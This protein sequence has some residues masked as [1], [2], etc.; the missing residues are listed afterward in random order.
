VCEERIGVELP[1]CVDIQADCIVNVVKL[2]NL[3]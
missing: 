1:A 2:D 3:L